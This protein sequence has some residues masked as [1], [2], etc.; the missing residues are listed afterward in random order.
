[1]LAALPLAVA[2]VAVEG[3][4]AADGED[5]PPLARGGEVDDDDEEEEG[6]VMTAAFAVTACWVVEVELLS[7]S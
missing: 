7:E 1:M 4:G 2:A 5:T 6:A 3:E